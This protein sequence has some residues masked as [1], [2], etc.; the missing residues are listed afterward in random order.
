TNEWP[1]GFGAE[2]TVRAGN[3]AIS[4]WTVSW[5]WPNGQRITN[6]WNASITSSGSSVTAGNAGHNG[7]VG[8]NGSTTFGFNGSWSGTNS[9]P[10]LSCTAR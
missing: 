6:S 4:G 3:T 9:A 1:G 8:A 7:A 2:V 5:T 10:T